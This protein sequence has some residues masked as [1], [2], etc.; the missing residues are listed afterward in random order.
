[1]TVAGTSVSQDSPQSVTVSVTVA[2]EESTQG[3][4]P[5]AWRGS[6]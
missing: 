6:K 4:A 1:M 5:Y 2:G 3:G